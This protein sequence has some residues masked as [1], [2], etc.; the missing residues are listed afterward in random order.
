M[1]NFNK[2]RS[3]DLLMF[4]KLIICLIVCIFNLTALKAQ[5]VISKSIF[6][7]PPESSK[8][9]TYWYFLG[10]QITSEG[11]TKDLEEMKKVGIGGALMFNIS[12][13]NVDYTN[14]FAAPLN[15]VK[16][17]VKYLSPDYYRMVKH[18]SDESKRLGLEFG[19]HNAPGWSS[20]GGPWITKRP[21]LA[22]HLL[23]VSTTKI[24]GSKHF[25]G[26]L[27]KPPTGFGFFKLS[28]YWDI[29]VLAF[30]TPKDYLIK[31][32]S[33]KAG[34]KRDTK[35]TEDTTL[36]D[37]GMIIPS[38]SIRDLT[39]RMDTSGLLT[40]DVPDGDWTI[41]RIGYTPTGAISSVPAGEQCLECDKMSS[42][43]VKINWNGLVQNIIN[44]V[45]SDALKVVHIDSYEVGCQNWT[46]EFRKEF[47]KRRGYDMTPFF[48]IM[49]G[50]VIKSMEVSE[51]FLWD[52]RQT[53]GDLINEKYYSTM[54][55]LAHQ[56]GMKISAEPY[57]SGGFRDI[58][59]GG[60][61]DIPMGEF[62]TGTGKSTALNSLVRDP[63]SSAHLYGKK[64]VAAE[65]FTSDF[66]DRGS[67]WQA[68]PY[69]LKQLGDL[70]FCSGVNRY[71]LH[72][73]CHQP[74]TDRSP[75]Y[76]VR[77]YGVQFGWTNTWWRQSSAW[78]QYIAR[79][80]YLLQKGLYVSDAVRFCG[81]DTPSQ[82]S[83]TEGNSF[84][85]CDADAIIHRMS[86]KNG[87]IVLPDGMNYKVLILD[88]SQT[89]TYEL[90]NKIS[91]LVAGGAIIIGKKPQRSPSLQ[92][93]PLC[94]LSIK[95]LADKMWGN[96]DGN[97]VKMNVFGAGKVYYNE[98]I[99]NVLAELT[100]P[101]FHVIGG[102]PTTNIRYTHRVTNDSEIYF[103][104][105]QNERFESVSGTF[106]VSGKVPEIWFPE[107]GKIT[108]CPSFNERSGQTT[109][110]LMLA[111]FESVFVVFRKSV[112]SVNRI[113]SITKNGQTIYKFNDGTTALNKY[114]VAEVS[115]D[116]N[117]KLKLV[118]WEPG[119]YKLDTIEVN[120][121]SL[122]KTIT[123]VGPWELS[124]PPNLGAPNSAVFDS[125]TS[126]TTNNDNGIKYFS[127]TATYIK[128]IN[129][130]GEI[131]RPDKIV[132][133]DM[134]DVKNI[135]E[136]T[137]NG[138]SFGIFWKPPFRV[139][140]TAAV[141]K[142]VNKLQI[143]VTNNWPNRIIGYLVLN[144]AITWKT[145]TLSYTAS[146]SLFESGLL[147]PVEIRVA[148]KW[149]GNEKIKQHFSK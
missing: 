63:A 125:L 66:T 82:G 134:G 11:I 9:N 4:I 49:T 92:N 109:V 44:T 57:G 104:S 35:L 140:I 149:S 117:G 37:P 51:R 135:A 18:A 72:V 100:V 102:D 119:L 67:A 50:L 118:A 148:E 98:T 121:P 89:M 48:P 97:T 7:S 42:T 103:L 91:K 26:I 60:K 8:P 126:W 147:G 40:W 41:M 73:Y 58:S 28:N 139:D 122:P 110:P 114:P 70:A 29:A 64:I 78:F 124:F 22:M 128:D 16:L 116:A 101:D 55:T 145:W 81:E 79:C 113:N 54:S 1:M 136:V 5:E 15:F 76:S 14:N 105:N 33:A 146:S 84:D 93:Y 88:K 30:P 21:E 2:Y 39:S 20:S 62:W 138:I 86:V 111:P 32:W 96:I 23:T 129:L 80:Q 123:T 45:G 130:P 90:L 53:I 17:G 25:S 43:A 46:P 75:G 107:T 56:N 6:A 112:K 27:P 87:R 106:R 142:G 47:W 143:K 61:L 10:D 3:G 69:A 85:A 141:R 74:F 137:L 127:G 19:I 34:Y 108:N 38:G 71:T 95:N 65:A 77:G 83:Y 120:V 52:V 94:D 133:L 115:E 31:N 24:V 132:Y 12:K 36:L 59:V 144:Q 131:I 13:T 99:E 68:H